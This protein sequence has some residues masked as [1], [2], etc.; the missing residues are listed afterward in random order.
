MFSFL[1]KKQRKRAEERRKIEE[2]A[3][4]I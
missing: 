3:K 4:G 1:I 2:M